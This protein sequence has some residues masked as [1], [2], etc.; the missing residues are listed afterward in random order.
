M[1]A[2][3]IQAV[4]RGYI[5]RKRFCL[6]FG[7]LKK[8]TGRLGALVRG[9]KVRSVLRCVKVQEEARSLRV[10]RAEVEKELANATLGSNRFSQRRL[11]YLKS[12]LQAELG[13][14]HRR[15]RELYEEGAWVYEPRHPF[16]NFRRVQKWSERK[17]VSPMKENSFNQAELQTVEFNPAEVQE[18]PKKKRVRE[19]RDNARR[20]RNK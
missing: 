15:F 2:E 5:A 11:D 17:Q 13:H 12:S 18:P 6:A 4:F 14:F 3:K 7:R 9:W 20:G 8:F 16:P 19:M 10:K 1:C